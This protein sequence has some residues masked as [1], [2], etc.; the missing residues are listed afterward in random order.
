[1]IKIPSKNLQLCFVI[2]FLYFWATL[3]NLSLAKQYYLMLD[4]D[5]DIEA[6]PAGKG[7]GQIVFPEVFPHLSYI[8]RLTMT[9]TQHITI[10]TILSFIDSLLSGNV[11]FLLLIYCWCFTIK[12]MLF[13]LQ[14]L[15][16]FS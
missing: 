4:V 2:F 12:L 15:L 9:A 10:K 6:R 3:L 11:F 1:M 8:S 5:T 14:R 13:G 7:I 16:P